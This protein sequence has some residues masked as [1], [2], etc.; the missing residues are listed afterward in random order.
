MID[1]DMPPVD[2]VY[3]EANGLRLHRLEFGGAGR[4]ILLVHGVGGGAWVWREVAPRLTPLGRVV[5]PDLRGYGE[6]Q[7]SAT[8]A[9]ATDDHVDDLLALF[10]EELDV[11]GFSW[12]GL[13]GL[14]LAARAPERVRRLAIVDIAPSSPLGEREVLPLPLVCADHARAL[15]AERALAPRAADEVLAAVA[16]L[17]T[18][19]GEDGRLVRKLDPF[20]AERWPFRAD[21]RWA[22]LAA[23]SCPVLVVRG[24]DSPV[25][26]R[27]EADRMHDHDHV[28]LVELPGCGHLVPLER[29]AELAAALTEF[30]A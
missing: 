13:V 14:A 24:A 26:S 28:R 17:Q 9:Y 22:E 10:D 3:A 25:L 12:G 7:W 5:A 8:G 18:R 21:D 15:E 11:V 2:H 6:S 30:L 20:F 4:A 1:G 19:P 16:A 27:E 23:L 29:P